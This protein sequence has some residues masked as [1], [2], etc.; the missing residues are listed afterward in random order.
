M[1]LLLPDVSTEGTVQKRGGK[2]LMRF[3]F[4]EHKKFEF[5]ENEPLSKFSSFLIEALYYA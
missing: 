1:K 3:G 5:L 4:C 2:K